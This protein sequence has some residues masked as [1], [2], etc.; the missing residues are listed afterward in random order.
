MKKATNQFSGGGTYISNDVLG[1]LSFK[2]I[3]KWWSVAFLP[4]FLCS[5]S[6]G[7]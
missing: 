7:G 2:K 6:L 1:R 4:R 3:Y 5:E